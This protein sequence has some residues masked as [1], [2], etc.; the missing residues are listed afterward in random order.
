MS[1]GYQWRIRMNRL[2]IDLE[3]ATLNQLVPQYLK[4]DENIFSLLEVK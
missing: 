3:Q 1:H 2:Q 4:R